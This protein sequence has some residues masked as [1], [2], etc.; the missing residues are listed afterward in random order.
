MT[1]DQALRTLEVQLRDGSIAEL[2][3]LLPFDLTR[4][5]EGFA[6]LSEAS[7]FARFGMGIS[8]L[9][10]Q[11]LA[12]LTNVDLVNHMAW[13]ATV[14][15]NPAGVARY[16]V[17][18]GGVAA[19]VAVTVVDR[20]QQIGLG[21]E[22]FGALTAAARHDGLASFSFEVDP[23]NEPVLKMLSRLPKSLADSGLVHGEVAIA[24]LPIHQLEGSF[25]ELLEEYRLLRSV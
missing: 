23:S 25:V 9:S 3:P 4:L 24:D 14:S 20:F 5:E 11:E 1:E 16:L 22:L 15:D 21:T 8:H 12:Y 13:G 7:R 17:L 2:R 19:E 6:G 18:P 10:H